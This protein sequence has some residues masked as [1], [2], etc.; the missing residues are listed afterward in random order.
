[1]ALRFRTRQSVNLL[2][3][4]CRPG[5]PEAAWSAADDQSTAYNVSIRQEYQVTVNT[6]LVAVFIILAVSAS[7]TSAQP[8]SSLLLASQPTTQRRHPRQPHPGQ[9]DIPSYLFHF[10]P[11]SGFSLKTM[12]RRTDGRTDRSRIKVPFSVILRQTD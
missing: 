4:C 7:G 8:T 2:G 10:H 5:S 11:L 3:T 9:N 1:V 6:L 12:D